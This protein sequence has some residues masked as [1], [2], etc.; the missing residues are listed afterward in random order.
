[1]SAV[2]RALDQLRA[3]LRRRVAGMVVRGVVRLVDDALKAQTLQVEMPGEDAPDDVEHVQPF[4]L[5]FRPAAG[6]EVLVLSVGGD[7][8]Y[9]V[10]VLAQNRDQRPAA[11]VAE[12]EGGLYQAGAY[13]VFLES[14]GTVHLGAQSAADFVARADRVEDRLN[15]LEDAFLDH[16][17]PPIATSGGPQPVLAPGLPPDATDPYELQ[18]GPVA[19]DNVRAT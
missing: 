8:D 5:S 13:L 19:A 7:R 6:S 18:R 14:G 15:E 3:E 12:G 1:M 2:G 11:E 17:H 10:A 4:G 9:P 16:V